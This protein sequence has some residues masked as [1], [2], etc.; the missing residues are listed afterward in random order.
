MEK[1]CWRGR[2]EMELAVEIGDEELC[3]RQGGRRSDKVNKLETWSNDERQ[4]KLEAM[5]NEA[6]TAQQT[7]DKAGQEQSAGWK[8]RRLTKGERWK[9][10]LPSLAQATPPAPPLSTPF[11]SAALRL[12]QITQRRGQ[13]GPTV[14]TF[15]W[16]ACRVIVAVAI[17]VA[18]PHLRFGFLKAEW[19]PD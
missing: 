12:S 2:F 13:A 18:G 17:A 8:D 11:T 15:A 14:C 1:K 6:N 10:V 19:K 9:P 7:T 16:S 5:L 4:T 3:N